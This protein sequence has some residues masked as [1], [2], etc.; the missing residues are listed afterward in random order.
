MDEQN[1]GLS[2]EKTEGARASDGIRSTIS[3]PDMVPFKLQMKVNF[4]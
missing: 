3:S 4:H 2:R 1:A